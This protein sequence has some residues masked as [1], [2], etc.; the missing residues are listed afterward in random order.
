VSRHNKERRRVRA[1]KKAAMLAKGIRPIG[2]AK[3]TTRVI[4]KDTEAGPSR[5]RET[6]HNP[7]WFFTPNEVLATTPNIL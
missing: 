5:H 6:K 3:D 2:K 1:K 4:Y 7:P